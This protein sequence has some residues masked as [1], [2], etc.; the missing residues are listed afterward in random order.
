MRGDQTGLRL[1]FTKY[2]YVPDSKH[3]YYLSG[4][5]LPFPLATGF[6]TLMRWH[7]PFG[8]QSYFRSCHRHKSYTKQNRFQMH[9]CPIKLPL[10]TPMLITSQR[11]LTQFGKCPPFIFPV[12][13][14]FRH[15]TLWLSQETFS[16]AFSPDIGKYFCRC[17][18]RWTLA[19]R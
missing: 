14:A 19:A 7:A 6:S 11:R 5:P 4:F 8:S 13:R 9:T 17:S 2:Q 16:V 18:Y 1:S 3:F 12:S 10:Y 15:T